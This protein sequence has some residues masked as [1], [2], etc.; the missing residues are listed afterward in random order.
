MTTHQRARLVSVLL[1]LVG[2]PA[3]AHFQMLLPEK[4]S[5]RRGEAVVVHYRWGH[6]FEHQ[7]FDAP[8]TQSFFSISPDGQKTDLTRNLRKASEVSG[9]KK[10]ATYRLSFTPEQ[11]GD[12]LFILNTPPIWMEEE[13]A[14]L[15]D[16]VKV[17]LH[18]QAQKGWDASAGQPIEMMPL[19]RPYGLQPGMVFQAQAQW[20]QKPLAGA[21]I[22]IERYNAVAPDKL[23]PDEHITRTGKTD[24]NGCLACTLTEPGWWCLTAHHDGVQREHGGKMYPVRRRATLWV[25]VD[26]RQGSGA[27]GQRSEIRG[28]KSEVRGQRSET[29]HLTQRPAEDGRPLTSR[30]VDPGAPA[31]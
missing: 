1:S 21:L 15:Q 2:G 9:E 23:P 8:A 31:S 28:Q 7:L 25:F 6:P 18:V 5:V 27:K 10:A 20:Q 13:Q 11:R 14:F 24:P 22:E 16:S 29:R 12:Y 26:D 3:A 30:T 19:T 4:A 17:V